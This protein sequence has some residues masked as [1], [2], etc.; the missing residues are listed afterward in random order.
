M[1]CS[2]MGPPTLGLAGSMMLTHKVLGAGG[3]EI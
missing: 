1:L 3:M 2:M